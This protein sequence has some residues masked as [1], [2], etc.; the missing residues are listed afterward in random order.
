MSKEFDEIK[1]ELEAFCYRSIKDVASLR[2]LALELE[3][4][5]SGSE[6]PP[7]V[8]LIYTVYIHRSRAAAIEAFATKVLEIIFK[9]E[10]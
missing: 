10:S 1:I 4:R 8:D 6:F 5:L 2:A 7:D 9:G 3:Q